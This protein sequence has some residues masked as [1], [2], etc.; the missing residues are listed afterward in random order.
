MNRPERNEPDDHPLDRGRD[1]DRLRRRDGLSLAELLDASASRA[2][3][4]ELARLDDL[5][6]DGFGGIA[7][8]TPEPTPERLESIIDAMR[9]A[10]NF[11]MSRRLRRS[12]RTL[13][14]IVALFLSVLGSYA[15][16][17]L[18]LRAL[19]R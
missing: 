9:T 4:V 6:G 7:R 2:E 14:W 11:A 19:D 17:A 3:A 12:V 18:A 13:L 16:V 5:L 1:S 15:F 8:T 10:S